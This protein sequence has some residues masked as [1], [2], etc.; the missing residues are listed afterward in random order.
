MR[1]IAGLSDRRALY[2][3]DKDRIYFGGNQS[4]FGEERLKQSG[5]GIIA[6]ANVFMRL[7]LL[8]C[9]AALYENRGEKTSREEYIHFI[10]KLSRFIRPFYLFGISFGIWNSFALKRG[11]KRYAE[12]C[13]L[14]IRFEERYPCQNYDKTREWLLKNLREGRP[15]FVLIGVS[16]RFRDVKVSYIG[17]GELCGQN[18]A[19][20]WMSVS[21]LLCDEE[22]EEY[23]E[24][25]TWGGTARIRLKDWQRG[26]W[27]QTL[28][29]MRER[30]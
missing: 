14:R 16:R 23:L 29:C 6:A 4:W 22:G 24:V 30:A 27:P 18:L 25:L 8:P 13:K 12:A 11:I 19:L 3:Y 17:G 20:H 26:F 15:L 28:L 2:I 5:C 9:F 21:A 10:E 7:S 1:E